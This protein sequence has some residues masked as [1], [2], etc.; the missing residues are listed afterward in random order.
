MKQELKTI[1]PWI[2]LMIIVSA[3][4]AV[5]TTVMVNDSLER[6][7]QQLQETDE[8]IRI[9]QE[10]PDPVPGTYEE[11]LSYVKEQA[12]DIAFITFD[13]V[14]SD[15]WEDYVNTLGAVITSDGWML[16]AQSSGVIAGQHVA[17]IDG[18]DYQIDD[19]VDGDGMQLVH[20][21]DA[22]DLSP[23]AFGSSDSLETGERVFAFGAVDDFYV[24]TLVNGHQVPTSDTT[25]PDSL[26]A[27]DYEQVAFWELQQSWPHVL[28]VNAAGELVALS[29][30]L[31]SEIVS[32][33]HYAL[34]WIQA[35]IRGED[36]V[37]PRLGVSV[38][39]LDALFV[40]T[41]DRTSG[42]LVQQVHDRDSIFAIDDIIVRVGGEV[43]DA[44]TPLAEIL[45]NYEAGDT[46]TVMF[47]RDGESQESD[48][49]LL[50]EDLV[51]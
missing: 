11:A 25:P 4:V 20:I 36:Y 27:P 32:P 40:N 42:A 8:L 47:V 44:K 45:L 41:S 21:V 39:W 50:G 10:R 17:W 14:A 29:D 18:V 1:L 28:I 12:G 35:S 13:N 3:C 24:T 33:M 34:P 5:V 49:E 26:W 38:M 48:V 51:Y 23:F 16:A 15:T 30:S 2:I 7:A 22:P 19:V 43:I 37:A 31:G 9:S 6:Y 46:V